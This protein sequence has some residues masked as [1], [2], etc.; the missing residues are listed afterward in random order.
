MTTIWLQWKQHD[1]N[2][3]IMITMTT[4]VEVAPTLVRAFESERVG[5]ERTNQLVLQSGGGDDH[6]NDDGR[7]YCKQWISSTEMS[8]S[9]QLFD[10][11]DVSQ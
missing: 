9:W 6:D 3:N 4:P 8:P 2:D 5:R 7:G 11:R 10:L 1:Y